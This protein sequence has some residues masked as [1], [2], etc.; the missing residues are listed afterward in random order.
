MDT[1]TGDSTD[2]ASLLT[3]TIQT[4]KGTNEIVGTLFGT[5]D[6]AGGQH[7]RVPGGSGS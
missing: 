7:E 5:K 4:D 2:Y 1:K 3:V 6:H